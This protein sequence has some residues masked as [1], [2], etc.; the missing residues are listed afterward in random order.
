MAVGSMADGETGNGPTRWRRQPSRTGPAAADLVE[1]PHLRCHSP[2]GRGWSRSAAAER[3][4]PRS[5]DASVPP[6]SI[7]NDIIHNVLPLD[8]VVAMTEADGEQ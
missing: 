3:P 8:A 4:S 7:E 5:V 1:L 6:S 2:G